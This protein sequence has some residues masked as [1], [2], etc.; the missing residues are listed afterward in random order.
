MKKKCW[1]VVIVI[2]LVSQFAISA[3]EVPK[4]AVKLVKK[5][6]EAFQ[7]QK[8]DKA[9]EAYNNAV[10]LAPEYAAAY[11]GLGRL[12]LTQKNLPE[13]VKNLE[14]ALELDPENAEAKKFYAGVLSQL[15]SQVFSQRQVNQSSSYFLKLTAIPGIDQ[16]TPEIY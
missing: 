15:G 5:A 2:L 8:Y 10:Q 9:L 16:L 12:Q 3:A 1:F 11:I 14:K 13:A 6:D 7:K 4:K